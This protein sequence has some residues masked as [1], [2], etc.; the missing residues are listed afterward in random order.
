MKHLK[1]V[2]VAFIIFN[3]QACKKEIPV[4]ETMPQDEPQEEV[5]ADPVETPVQ[6]LP[7]EKEDPV[8]QEEPTVI[9]E[10]VVEAPQPQIR[11]FDVVMKQ[12]EFVPGTI[13]VNEGDTVRMNVTST[14]VDHGI[15]ISAFG[16]NQPVKAG[17]TEQI[18]FVADKKGT[19]TIFCSV[20]CGS[21]HGSMKGTLIVQ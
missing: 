17:D 9:E 2:L 21:G 7:E 19:Y 20:F 18:E 11:T 4:E 14:D 15:A 5:S 6:E 13:T 12:W 8:V 1:I 16:V 10:P 3:F